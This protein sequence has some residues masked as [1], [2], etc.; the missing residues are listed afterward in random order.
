MPAEGFIQV[1][2]YTTSEAQI[3]VPGAAV[4]IVADDG[5]FWLRVSPMRADRSSRWPSRC[6]MLRR[7]ATPISGGKPFT[8]VSIRVQHPDY[9]QIQV[10]NAQVFARGHHPAAPGADSPAHV[11]GAV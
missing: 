10:D 5:R 11:S 9:E 8:T 4:A 1:H 7:A 2:V 6:R 3:P